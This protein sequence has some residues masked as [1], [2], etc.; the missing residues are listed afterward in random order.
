M[1]MIAAIL[2]NADIDKAY[3]ALSHFMAIILYNAN[4]H[5]RARA[6]VCPQ[7]PSAFSL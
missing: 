5:L 6:R 1:E 3:N 2:K 4:L 7:W